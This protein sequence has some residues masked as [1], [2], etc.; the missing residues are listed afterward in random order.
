MNSIAASPTQCL[1]HNPTKLPYPG[2]AYELQFPALPTN[3]PSDTFRNLSLICLLH[4]M[5]LL[6]NV[7]FSSNSCIT[8]VCRMLFRQSQLPYLFYSPRPMNQITP[9]PIQIIEGSLKSL[10]RILEHIHLE[11][12]E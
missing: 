1:P 6:M 12:E 9:F 11:R 4:I 8:E 5:S 3:T 2:F 10:T 7:D